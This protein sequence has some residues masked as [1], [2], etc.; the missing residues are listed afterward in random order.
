[1]LFI[2]NA[3]K[4]CCEQWFNEIDLTAAVDADK[5]LKY[6]GDL[7]YRNGLYAEA[8]DLYQQCQGMKYIHIFKGT[9]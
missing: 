7:A 4:C 2:L 6:Q 5:I 3:Y 9:V 1:M 8:L